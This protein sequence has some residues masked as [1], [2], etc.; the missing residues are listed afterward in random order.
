MTPFGAKVREY[1]KQR[2]ITLKR[3]AEG[4]GVTVRR[5]RPFL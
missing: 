2:G 1:R 3:M 5:T 4:L